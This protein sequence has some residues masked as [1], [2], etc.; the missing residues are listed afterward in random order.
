MSKHTEMRRL[1]DA[2]NPKNGYGVE[3]ADSQWYY[4]ESWIAKVGEQC[5][6]MVPRA[7]S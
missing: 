1:F 3:L 2:K 4:Y 7:S 5:Q 6:Q